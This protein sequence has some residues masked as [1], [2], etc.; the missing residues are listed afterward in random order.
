MIRD[1]ESGIYDYPIVEDKL[2]DLAET[3][4]NTNDKKVY[5]YL[6]KPAKARKAYPVT[7]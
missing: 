5:G 1:M 6:K 4:Q 7:T 2:V 3:L